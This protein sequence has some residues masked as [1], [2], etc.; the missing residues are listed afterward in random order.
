MMALPPYAHTLGVSLEMEAGRPLLIMPFGNDVIGR[1]GFVH[2]GALAGL[3]ELAAIVGLRHALDAAD[4]TAHLFKPI[5]VTTDFMR[6][7]R[8]RITYAQAMVSRL[9]TRVANVEAVAWQDARDRPVAAARLNFK[10]S[11]PA[12]A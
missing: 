5:N 11:A 12:S 6:G 3:L 4:R 2:G 9:G 8:D 10:I 1:P 7:G